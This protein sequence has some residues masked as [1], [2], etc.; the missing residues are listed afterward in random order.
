MA[1]PTFPPTFAAQLAPVDENEATQTVQ[2]LPTGTPEHNL[3]VCETDPYGYVCKV[4]WAE[5]QAGF[6]ASEFPTDP[7]GFAFRSVNKTEPGEISI[8]YGVI[9][10]GGYLYLSQGVGSKFP[11]FTGE[12]PE[13]AIEPVMVGENYGEYV[14][15]HWAIG[16]IYKEYTWLECCMARLRWVD[17]NRWF[18]I[19]K[20]A[21]M[22]Q[23]D[24]M[25]REVMIDMALNLVDQPDPKGNLRLE[26]LSLEEASQLVDFKIMRLLK[27]R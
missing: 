8:E 21:A 6:D 13:D 19:Y 16:G 11:V 4:A 2:P 9:G 20:Q 23:T 10:G 3:S 25:T 27:L 26:Y 12:A 18:E 24:Y 14:Y 1:A 15:G 22:P 7:K 5:K 17:G